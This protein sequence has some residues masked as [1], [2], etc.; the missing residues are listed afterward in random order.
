MPV[1]KYRIHGPGLPPRR[2]ELPVPGWG[3][4]PMPRTDGSHE[5]VWHCA[6]FSESARYG[7]EILYP[8]EQELRVTA[9]DEGVDLDADWG[10]NPQNGLNWPPFR[11][12]GELYY[13]YQIV[14]DLKVEPGWAIRMEP[15]PRYYADAVGD[16][17]LAVP[18]LIRSVWWPMMFFVI[19]K[20]PPRGAAHV[21]RKGEGFAQ[22][23]VIPGEPDLTLEPMGEEEAAERELQSRRIRDSRDM[24]SA[25]TRWLSTTNTVFD[26]TYRHMLRAAKARDRAAAEVS[27]VNKSYGGGDDDGGVD[28]ST[29]RAARR[30]S[31]SHSSSGADSADRTHAGDSSAGSRP[32][33]APSD[34]GRRSG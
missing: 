15:H 20:A 17:P 29:A 24:L 18:A 14:L 1:V 33:R 11:R 9:G 12:F 2:T 13:S 30:N 32:A 19:F 34:S 3:G 10:P 23:I 6:P 26:G 5:Q 28:S 16:V 27:A 21:F 7:L 22:A 25:K 31:R 4:E 8:F